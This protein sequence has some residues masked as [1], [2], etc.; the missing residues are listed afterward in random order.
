MARNYKNVEYFANRP[1]I[2]K[3]FEDLAKFLDYCR[4]EMFPFNEAD[5]YNR[6]SWQWR[7]FEKSLRG[8]KP[9]TTNKRPTTQRR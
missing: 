1:D 3:I 4:S 5:L 6:A 9:N 7:H 8:I 2:V